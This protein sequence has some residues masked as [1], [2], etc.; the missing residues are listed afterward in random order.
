MGVTIKDIASYTGLSISTVSLVLNGKAE[1]CRISKETVSK[2]EKA[3]EL[4]QYKPNLLASSLRRGF[5]NIIGVVISDISN[6][7][8]IQIVSC[9]EKE[10]SLYGYSTMIVGSDEDDNKC[11]KLIDSF[12]NFKVDGLILAV[13]GGLRERIIQLKNQKVPFVLLDRY[14]K[15]VN[16]N[17]VIM[18]NYKSAY[19]AVDYLIK[20]GRRRIATFAYDV[21]MCHMHDRFRG[22][23]DALKDNG[24]RYDK[25]LTP[26]V[27]FLNVD[28]CELKIKMKQLIENYHIDAVF[29]QTTKVALPCIRAIFDFKYSIPEQIAVLCFHDNEFFNI[30]T[31]AITALSQPVQVMGRDCAHI[32]LNDIKGELVSPVKK[33]YRYSDLLEREIL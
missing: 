32:L 28:Y 12:L 16:V 22:Y 7:F 33:V 30:M 20:K 10:L 2:V 19:M 8:F 3:K 17:M 6:P 25:R 11:N 5:T 18:D 21:D 4:L 29:F 24:I 1:I 14:F 9:I 31:P 27:P 23:R 13:S 15:G 26:L